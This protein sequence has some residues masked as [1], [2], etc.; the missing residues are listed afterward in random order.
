MPIVLPLN[1]KSTAISSKKK[2]TILCA[3]VT[4]LFTISNLYQYYQYQGNIG[5]PRLVFDFYSHEH[6]ARRNVH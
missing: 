5:N 3:V 2:R 6:N 1:K 4:A